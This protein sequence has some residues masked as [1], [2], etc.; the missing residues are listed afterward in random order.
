MIDIYIDRVIETNFEGSGF[1]PRLSRRTK[2]SRVKSGALN[3]S[4]YGI[5]KRNVG[6]S[7]ISLTNKKELHC[8][9]F[10]VLYREYDRDFL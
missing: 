8:K 3:L 7:H 2:S 6:A 4:S 9:I 5:V 10:R 1:E